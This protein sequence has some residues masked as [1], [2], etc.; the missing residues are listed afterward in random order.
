MTL[1]YSG[2]IK[3]AIAFGLS[4][5]IGSTLTSKRGFIVSTTLSVVLFTTIIMGGLMS[6]FLK[7]LVGVS[8]EKEMVD[9]L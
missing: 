4:M 1:S 3:G 7:K 2:I 5:Q 8:K 6:F 9:R